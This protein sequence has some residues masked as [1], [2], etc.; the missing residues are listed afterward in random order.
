VR[1]GP[2]AFVLF[3]FWLTIDL[4]GITSPLDFKDIKVTASIRGMAAAFEKPP[5]RIAGTFAT[6]GKKEDKS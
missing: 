3:G 1:L 5:T 6:F 4:G 2:V